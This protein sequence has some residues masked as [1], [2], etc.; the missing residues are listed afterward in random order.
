MAYEL[1]REV[2]S[3]PFINHFQRLI[4]DSILEAACGRPINLK[5]KNKTTFLNADLALLVHL[6]ISLAIYV[7]FLECFKNV[8]DSLCLQSHDKCMVAYDY[9]SKFA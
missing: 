6:G 3:P 2:S 4:A 1:I 5:K 7:L 8:R 9:H